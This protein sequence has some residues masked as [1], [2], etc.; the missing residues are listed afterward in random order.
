MAGG[1][2][3]AVRVPVHLSSKCET[4]FNPSAAKNKTKK[5]GKRS[6]ASSRWHG[7]P[8]DFLSLKIVLLL[9]AGGS[10]L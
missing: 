7:C 2:A 5:N 9:D 4:K 6:S 10:H 3:Q 8:D 1:V